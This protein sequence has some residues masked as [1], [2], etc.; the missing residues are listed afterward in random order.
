M[1]CRC[2]TCLLVV[3]LTILPACRCPSLPL[4][5][6]EALK[7]NSSITSVNLSAN[8]IGDEGVQV[9]AQQQQ[10]QQQRKSSRHK[11]PASVCIAG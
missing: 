4:Q 3:S 11:A 8:H 1:I 6:F 5:L 7:S 2:P 10:Q 9:R